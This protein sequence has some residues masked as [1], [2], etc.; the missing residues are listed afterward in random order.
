MGK[1][2]IVNRPHYNKRR[3]RSAGNYSGAV[4]RNRDIRQISELYPR[5]KPG[6]FYVAPGEHFDK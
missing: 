5:N 1:I 2:L 3:G 4:N 6:G